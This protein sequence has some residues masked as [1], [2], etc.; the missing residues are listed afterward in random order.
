MTTT[1]R[2]VTFKRP[3]RTNIPVVAGKK[4]KP[5]TNKPRK[6]APMTLPSSRMKQVEDLDLACH[7]DMPDVLAILSLRDLPQ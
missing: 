3:I 6:G 5:R 7:E 2:T 4:S 1:A